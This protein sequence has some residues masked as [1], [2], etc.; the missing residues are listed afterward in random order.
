M[1]E[2]RA[3]KRERERSQRVRDAETSIVVI[4]HQTIHTPNTSHWVQ[5]C[6]VLLARL[7]KPGLMRGCLIALW[8]AFSGGATE[9]P[10]PPHVGNCTLPVLRCVDGTEPPVSVMHRAT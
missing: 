8:L 2:R 1:R 6:N 10:I 5:L 4:I 7:R 3:R 9:D